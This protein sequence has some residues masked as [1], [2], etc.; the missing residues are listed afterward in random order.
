MDDFVLTLVPLDRIVDPDHGNTE[1]DKTKPQDATSAIVT[2]SDLAKMRTAQRAQVAKG[3]DAPEATVSASR[4]SV[5][6]VKVPIHVDYGLRLRVA[7]TAFINRNCFILDT[8]VADV[9]IGEDCSIGPNV[10]IIGVGHPVLFEDRCEFKTGKA[11]S[12]GARVEI[13]QGVWIGAGVT[14]LYLSSSL[15]HRILI[16]DQEMSQTDHRR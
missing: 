13:C 15:S 2:F 16:H 8:P 1:S 12:W 11:G 6:Y 7:P 3:G 10:T 5:P 4:P 14:I 9:V